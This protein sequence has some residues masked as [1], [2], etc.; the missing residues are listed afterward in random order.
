MCE[1]HRPSKDKMDTRTLRVTD[2]C[3]YAREEGCKILERKPEN[4]GLN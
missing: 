1:S 2:T 4:N 3:L